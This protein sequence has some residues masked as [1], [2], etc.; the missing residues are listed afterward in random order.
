MSLV[1]NVDLRCYKEA[2]DRE[3]LKTTQAQRLATLLEGENGG[4]RLGSRREGGAG[5]VVGGIWK[6]RHAKRSYYYLPSN[7]RYKPKLAD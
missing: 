2:H 3:L 7:Q 5:E 6:L 4:G 1:D